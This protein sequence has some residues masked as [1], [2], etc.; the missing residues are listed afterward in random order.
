MTRKLLL[1]VALVTI[2]LLVVATTAMAANPHSGGSGGQPGQTCQDLGNPIPS[3]GGSANAPGS[4]FNGDGVS[5]GMYAGSQP[6][7][8]NNPNSVSQYDVA[9]FQQTQR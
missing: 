8:S 3:P 4:P 1:C 5:G 6:Q 2:A 9:C 7:N